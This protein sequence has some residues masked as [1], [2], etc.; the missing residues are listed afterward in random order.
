MSYD[1]RHHRCKQIF[2]DRGRGFPIG[3]ISPSCCPYQRCIGGI[4]PFFRTTCSANNW[5]NQK[6]R[7]ALSPYSVAST[8]SQM[9][10]PRNTK[11]VCLL[12]WLIKIWCLPFAAVGV[13]PVAYL[14]GGA[15]RWYVRRWW[16]NFACRTIAGML[17]TLPSG[18]IFGF[19]RLN[20]PRFAGICL[21][22]GWSG[23]FFDE[24]LIMCILSDFLL[25]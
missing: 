18:R 6:L 7:K 23:F 19:G 8:A 15:G 13:L 22:S 14:P 12:T 11:V 1:I 3:R 9:F 10:S 24:T 4:C 17:E 2:V 21:E 20:A 5:Q 25:K 16:A